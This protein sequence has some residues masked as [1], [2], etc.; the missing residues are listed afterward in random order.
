MTIIVYGADLSPFTRKVLVCLVEKDIDYT[1][2]QVNPFAAPDWFPDISP[3]GKV[4]VI[5]DSA[6]GSDA[7]LP[8]STVICAYLE[9]K[10]PNPVLYPSE[11]FSL[12]RA[13]WYEEFADTALAEA[14][15]LPYFYALVV[16]R[17]MGQEADQET[18]EDA[19]QNKMPTR[20]AYLDGELAGREHFVGDTMTIADVA[21]ASQIV[22]YK[23]AGGSLDA[24]L[25]PNLAS[26]VDRMH[27]RPSFAQFISSGQ[28]FLSEA[29]GGD[30]QPG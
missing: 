30:Y 20:F 12:A 16:R 15:G 13:L 24:G 25:Y 19:V 26:F 1:L 27:V 17:L 6:V 18:A 3:M 2:E 14:I 29:L 10:Q 21:V 22:N 11:P 4:P 7:T 5:R 8:D 23:L 9:K 28:A